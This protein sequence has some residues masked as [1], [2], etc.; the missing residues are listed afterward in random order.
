M[1]Q[2]YRIISQPSWQVQKKHKGE[3][4]TVFYCKDE[5][6]AIRRKKDCIRRAATWAKLT[7]DEQRKAI[8]R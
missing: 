4:V 2:T 1:R 6:S 5:T 8:L 3:W 7:P